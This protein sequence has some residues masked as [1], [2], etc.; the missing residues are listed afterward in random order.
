MVIIVATNIDAICG[1]WSPVKVFQY[2][3]IFSLFAMLALALPAEE[4]LYH[5]SDNFSPVRYYFNAAFDVIQNPN[6]FSQSDYLAKHK[7]LMKRLASPL[8][9]IKRRGGWGELFKQEFASGRLLPNV[10]LHLLGS[11]YDYRYI[12]EYYRWHKFKYP[13][14][15]STLTLYMGHLG[16]EALELSNDQ[17]TIFDH[18]AD[19][20]V[21]DVLAIWLFQ[22]DQVVELFHHQLGMRRW[23]YQPFFDLQHGQI[24]NAG[25]NYIL[26]PS[27]TS[28]K[29]RPIF[30]TGMQT[31]IGTSYNYHGLKNI[32]LLS[33]VAFTDPLERKG[34]MV[35][36]LYLD[37]GRLPEF[38][39]TIN[40]SEN[41]SV[42]CNLYPALLANYFPSFQEQQMSL[43]FGHSRQQEMVIAINYNLPLGVGVVW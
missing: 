12:E 4:L 34:Y 23:A 7:R 42:R 1:T 28:S 27:L 26:R 32:S 39:I 36:A 21:F 25:L 10:A 37:N 20:F 35:G 5:K 29:W 30:M 16:N 33:G 41:Y 17:I 18:F 9:N 43:T 3:T 13:R 2:L 14:L 22:Y 31:M 40:G 19:L 24:R 6:Y 38:S 11:G 8:H 15:L